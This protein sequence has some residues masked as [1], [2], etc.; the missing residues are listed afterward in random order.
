MGIIAIDKEMKQELEVAIAEL[1]H[2]ISV[3]TAYNSFGNIG[4]VTVLKSILKKALVLPVEE[5]WDVPFNKNIEH[6]LDDNK[7]PFYESEYPNGV[8]IKNEN[9]RQ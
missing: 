4:K 1:E 8:L 9:E 7:N 2:L 5:S 6:I 3:N